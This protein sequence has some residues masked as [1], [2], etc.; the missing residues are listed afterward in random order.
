MTERLHFK[1]LGTFEV[2][3]KQEPITKF[4]TDKIRMLMAYLCLE[5]DRPHRR[6]TLS[7]LLWSNWEDKVAKHNLRQSLYRIKVTL[8]KHQEGLG[9]K[10]LHITRQEI[11]INVD[12]IHTDA[13]ELLKASLQLPIDQLEALA[14]SYKG[15]LLDGFDFV[16]EP[17]FDEWLKARRNQVHKKALELF[18]H[19][20]NEYGKKKQF[21]Q[22]DEHILRWISLDP[23]NEN[24][25]R[26]R[27]EILAKSGQRSQALA[28]YHTLVD[29][30]L[31]E[32]QA[33]PTDETTELYEQIH[34]EEIAEEKPKN[35]QKRFHIPA[36]STPF[37][38]R[39]SVLQTL[40]DKLLETDTRLLTIL[41]T[42]GMG[43]S[44]ILIE[45]AQ[46]IADKGQFFQD[47]I[48]FIPLTSVSSSELVPS[49]LSQSLGLSIQS[50]VGHEKQLLDFLRGREILLAWDNFEHLQEARHFLQSL[51][52]TAPK[53]KML[54]SSRSALNIRAEHRQQI[55][56]LSSDNA[57]ELFLQH[58]RRVHPDFDGQQT[59]GAITQVCD[60]V[61]G[62]PLAI[63]LA[64]SW[65]RILDC[66]SIVEEIQQ[67][68]EFLQSDWEDLPKRQ[69]S[70]LT[71]FEHTWEWLEEKERAL[72]AQATIFRGSFS[73]QAARATLGATARLLARLVD[74]ALLQREGSNR[75][76]MHALLKQFAHSKRQSQ[77][78]SS[79]TTEKYIT[80]YLELVAKQEARFLG[81]GV[82]QAMQ[83]IRTEL[84]NILYAWALAIEHSA[85]EQQLAAAKSL[86]YFLQHSG[87]SAEGQKLFAR[88]SNAIE[89][90][91]SPTRQLQ[92][93][94]FLMYQIEC[95]LDQEEPEQALPL[96]STLR[97]IHP[98]LQEYPSLYVRLQR[99][100]A[101]IQMFQGDYPKAQELFQKALEY[102]Q[103]QQDPEGCSNMWA[104]LGFIH[105][106]KGDYEPALKALHFGLQYDKKSGFK[107]G[108]TQKLNLIGLCQKA[109]G[110]LQ[111]A[112]DNMQDAIAS[113]RALGFRVEEGRYINNLG[114]IL[115]N[116]EAFDEAI[117][118]YQKAGL[119]FEEL[120]L[121]SSQTACIA[122][123]GV[124]YTH[125]GEFDKAEAAFLQTL[126]AR[127]LAQEISKVGVSQGNLGALYMMQGKD[128]QAHK[129]LHM[130]L[131]SET[132]HGHQ[133]ETARYHGILGEL[134][135]QQ[136]KLQ[137]AEDTFQKSLSLFRGL[138]RKIQICWILVELSEIFF[139][140][141]RLKAAQTACDEALLYAKELQRNDHLIRATA[142][143]AR[144]LDIQGNQQEAL[145]LLEPHTQRED[146]PLSERSRLYESIWFIRKEDEDYH[147][148]HELLQAYYEQKPSVRNKQRLSA[149]AN[150]RSAD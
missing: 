92:K 23:S 31:Q 109:V 33:D 49:A 61:G 6:D 118:Q 121:S 117:E 89:D 36:Q 16:D 91:Q 84:D 122:N 53:L 80:Y 150:S 138:K 82:L 69:R 3:W 7:G 129:Y 95:T 30:L 26:K 72:L 37:I 29:I 143:Q 86:S 136:G 19:L 101:R 18:E 90:L 11:Q 43:K 25:H 9:D 64:A 54:V 125:R 142:L 1:L 28:Q 132:L 141:N 135:V 44:R 88:A 39:Q 22:A 114:I 59:H 81:D 35:Q 24:A 148:A 51:L 21:Q 5:Q 48:Y 10:L 27:M 110:Q 8:N 71:I 56:G 105:W 93:L 83:T 149:L 12:N 112:K 76:S 134:Y 57:R 78:E 144:M 131:E 66:Q 67:D 124:I 14:Y 108:I 103:A 75:Y 115:R 106:Q 41:G 4:P 42:G 55:Q 113:A 17:L 68:L 2:T 140:Q 60:L 133:A 63:E 130:A 139:Q 145:S 99:V 74:K 47:G 127:L 116:M 128:E 34:Y 58:A 120:G 147:K 137:Q 77:L 62:S 38:G 50:T 87:L 94:S 100:E 97:S 123:L 15:P 98:E 40:Q 104:R 73:F 70:M 126:Q 111:Q 119:L 96:L 107:S 52:E 46:R 45:L 13:Q 85:F 20:T 32:F 79:H 65:V 146:Y 102:Y